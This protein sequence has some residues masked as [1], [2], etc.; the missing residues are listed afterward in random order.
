MHQFKNKAHTT[1]NTQLPFVWGLLE[2]SI[3]SLSCWMNS[4]PYTLL[5]C[6]MFSS[7]SKGFLQPSSASLLKDQEIMTLSW[8]TLLMFTESIFQTGSCTHGNMWTFG[9]NLAHIVWDKLCK[10]HLW[11]VFPFVWPKDCLEVPHHSHLKVKA[12]KLWK[13]KLAIIENVQQEL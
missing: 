11:P 7:R 13:K 3:D 5:S 9:E 1:S 8:S 12:G 10:T 6:Q 4:L 2:S